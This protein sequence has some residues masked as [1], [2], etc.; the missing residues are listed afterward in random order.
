MLYVL[1]AAV[2]V[3]LGLAAFFYA[4]TR[5]LSSRLTAAYAETSRLRMALAA[6]SRGATTTEI[7]PGRYPAT[8]GSYGGPISPSPLVR[9]QYVSGEGSLPPDP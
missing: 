2:L 4:R 5:V 6:G 7:Y 1:L 9:L 3:T 8:A